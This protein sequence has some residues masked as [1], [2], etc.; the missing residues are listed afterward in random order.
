MGL[1]RHPAALAAAGVGGDEGSRAF[2]AAIVV[3]SEA[4]FPARGF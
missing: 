1:R 4:R 3:F 2:R